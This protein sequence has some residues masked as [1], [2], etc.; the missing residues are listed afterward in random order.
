MG[1]VETSRELVEFVRRSPSMFHTVDTLRSYLDAAGAE[2]LPEGEPW[3]VAR[4]G[5]YYTVR[6]G[7]SLIAWRVGEELD[8]Y[9]FQ[10]CASHT[11]SPTYK[12]KSVA[13]LEG[14]AEYLRLDVEGYG[15]MIDYTWLDRPLSVAGRV[16]VREGDGVRS[17]LLS[18]DRDVLLIPSLAVHM[19]RDVNKGYA[20]NR[21]VDLCPL[22]S[23]G[24]LHRGDFDRMVAEALD[25]DPAD[26]VARDLF[27]VNRQ[28]GSVWGFADEFVS[29]PKL[30][31][32]QCDFVS[33]KAFLATANPH[34]VS[35]LA[36]FDNEEVGSNT[37]QGALSTFLRDTL[38]RINGALGKGDED[39]ARAVAK[40]FLV[41]CDN[42]HAV[43]P[44]HAEKSDEA[45]RALLN[46]GIVIK[47]AANQKYTTDAFSRAVMAELC[48]RAGVPVQ[49]FANRSDMAGGS[50]LGNLSNTQVSVHAVDVGLPQLAM[51]SSYET[52]GVCDTAYGIAAL[53]AFYGTDVQID[54][55][56]SVTFR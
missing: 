35:V 33:L 26:V 34:D 29:S 44:N 18:V 54:G 40:S 46:H 9:H 3:R 47:E 55:A 7:S 14:P 41:S 22:F 30:D 4:G 27:L 25:V 32:L 15:G 51:H 49:T 8:S 12:V 1:D 23:S 5:L 53:E 24:K 42:A 37:K 50:T 10:M 2:Y 19:N 11:D 45:N 56:E 48:R 6:N 38:R 28:E 21:Q 52:A 43:H 31:D 20:F 36:C 17:R 13:E 39:L 16:L